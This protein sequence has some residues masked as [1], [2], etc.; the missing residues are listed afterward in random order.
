MTVRVVGIVIGVVMGRMHLCRGRREK[1]PI[2]IG[3]GSTDE[4]DAR[5]HIPVVVRLAI[6]R[7][8]IVGGVVVGGKTTESYMFQVV[9]RSCSAPRSP[10][11]ECGTTEGAFFLSFLF[12]QY[13]E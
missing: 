5:G 7:D 13:F 9:G 11:K 6:D 8:A 1:E 3:K 10:T 12:F 2:I 4:T